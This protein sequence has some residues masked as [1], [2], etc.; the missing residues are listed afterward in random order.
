MRLDITNVR[1]QRSQINEK[2]IEAG[3]RGV[4]VEQRGG[5]EREVKVFIHTRIKQRTMWSKSDRKEWLQ[6]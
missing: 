4:I 5:E 2:E 6:N 1:L 3:R